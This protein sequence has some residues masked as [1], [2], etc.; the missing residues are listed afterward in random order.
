MAS[1]FLVFCS[2]LLAW[3]HPLILLALCWYTFAISNCLNPCR[4]SFLRG[5]LLYHIIEP[6]LY[7]GDNYKM[8]KS[9]LNTI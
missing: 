9:N 5:F 8:E 3:H 1:S 6:A 7:Q 4:S 2:H